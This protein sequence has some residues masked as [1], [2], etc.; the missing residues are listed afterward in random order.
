MFDDCRQSP[1]IAALVPLTLL[2]LTLTSTTAVAQTGGESILSAVSDWDPY[3]RD[4]SVVCKAD[5]HKVVEEYRWDLVAAVV[6]QTDAKCS[7]IAART[8]PS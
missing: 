3:A 6:S 8:R 2:L 5:Q 4:L 1:M 7:T